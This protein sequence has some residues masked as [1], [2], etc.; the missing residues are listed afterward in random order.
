ME[1]QSSCS[2]RLSNC[3]STPPV[4]KHQKEPSNGANT[5]RLKNPADALT[6]W[7]VSL[8]NAKPVQPNGLANRFHA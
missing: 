6:A 3:P 1:R 7:M 8:C 2:A 4:Q 5:L